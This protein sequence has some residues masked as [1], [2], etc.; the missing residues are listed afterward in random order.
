MREQQGQQRAVG[1]VPPQITPIEE[2]PR[3]QRPDWV[4]VL[5]GAIAAREPRAT[6][7]SIGVNYPP[8][9]YGYVMA[10]ARQR[11]M[12]LA[13]YQRRAALAFACL[14]LG[15]VW[16]DVMADEPPFGTFAAPTKAAAHA[17]GGYGH[18]VIRDVRAL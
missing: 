10:A 16:S 7:R 9:L 18:W 12:S 11:G 4:S 14:D 1:A 8:A 5:D 2:L 17:G 15:L 6:R 3:P 13:A